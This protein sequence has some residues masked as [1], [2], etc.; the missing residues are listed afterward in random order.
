MFDGARVLFLVDYDYDYDYEHEQ[1]HDAR[2]TAPGARA[3]RNRPH[4]EVSL[5]KAQESPRYNQDN[6]RLAS[7]Y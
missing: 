3:W 7:G 4:A 5:P 6:A 1:E 2:A